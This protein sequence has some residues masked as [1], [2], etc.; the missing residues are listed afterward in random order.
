MH[1]RWRW[2]WT[3]LHTR[4]RWLRAVEW[5]ADLVTVITIATGYMMTLGLAPTAFAPPSGLVFGGIGVLFTMIGTIGFGRCIR[6]PSRLALALYFGLQLMLGA[7][8]VALSQRVA[9][10]VLL[11]LVSQGF[12]IG[13]TSTGPVVALLVLA[14]WGLTFGVTTND[15]GAAATSAAGYLAG[16]VFVG[17]FTLIAVRENRARGD[18]ERLAAELQTSNQRLRE[19]A[20]KAEELATAQ[21]RNRMAREIHDSLGHYLTVINVQLEAARAIVDQDRSRALEALT[22]AQ[23][24]TQEGLAEVRRSVTALRLGD[25]EQRPLPVQLA[26]LVESERGDRLAIELIVAGSPRPLPPQ[27]ER[28]LYRVAQEGLTNVHRH[29][30]A[31]RIDLVLDYRAAGSVRLLVSDDGIG[32]ATTEGGFGL[33]GM[34]ERVHLLDGTV[35]VHTEPGKGFQLRVEVPG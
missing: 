24:L 8:I 20:A 28:T 4:W 26:E 35:T 19:Y 22:T 5:Q 12:I 18:I 30:R 16:V 1:A 9:A 23:R 33:L 34:R 10:A 14:A 32:A 3:G 6:R 17:I 11:P 27:T 21:E 13:P 15:W 29:A 2:W 25:E 7:L 31:Q